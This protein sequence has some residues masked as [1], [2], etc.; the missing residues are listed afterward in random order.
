MKGRRVGEDSKWRRVKRV[1][2]R[3]PPEMGME[4]VKMVVGSKL[5]RDLKR[6]PQF[7]APESFSEWQ[8]VHDKKGR[9]WG[10]EI[11]LDGDDEEEFAVGRYKG[12]YNRKTK[13]WQALV[14]EDGKPIRE[15]IAVNGWTT[16]K[17]DYPERKAYFNA[18]PTPENRKGKP[19]IEFIHKQNYTDEDKDEFGYPKREY[20]ERRKATMYTTGHKYKLH[21]PLPTARSDFMKNLIWEAY[22][23]A[24]DFYIKQHPGTERKDV[25][26]ATGFVVSKGAE[27]WRSWILEAFFEDVRGTEYYN[28][29]LE[30]YVKKFN[31]AKFNKD[32]GITYNNEEHREKFEKTLL[33]N[34]SV[35]KGINE[36]VH[37]LLDKSGPYYKDSFQYVANIFYAQLEDENDDILD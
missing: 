11:D 28:G 3:L 35:R 27:L 24:V 1:K 33:K 16:V 25:K 2:G 23:K 20:I 15:L 7:M 19:F 8:K 13:E 18:H 22:K 9:Y 6:R 37:N 36:L 4:H 32:K 5:A 21:M 12:K 14:D 29:L 10:E 26:I 34:D 30:K 17:S 31:R